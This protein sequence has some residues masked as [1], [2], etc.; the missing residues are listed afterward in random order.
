MRMKGYWIGELFSSI[1]F[2]YLVGYQLKGMLIFGNQ[3]LDLISS[4]ENTLF[5]LWSFAY[6]SNIW[7]Y[8]GISG[9]GYNYARWWANL[10]TNSLRFQ[11]FEKLAI[12]R[13][14]DAISASTMKRDLIKNEFRCST[15]DRFLDTYYLCRFLLVS[16]IN[17][18]E[19]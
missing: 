18:E 14:A 10:R 12:K 2:L 19:E 16:R 17:H 8:N 1:Y 5:G 9:M 13:K 7:L 15:S 11:S 4:E 6:F 3:C